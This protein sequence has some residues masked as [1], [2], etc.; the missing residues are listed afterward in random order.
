MKTKH[1]AYMMVLAVLMISA[2]FYFW[3]GS[4]FD[5]F[6]IKVYECRSHNEPLELFVELKDKNGTVIY[7]RGGLAQTETI[8]HTYNQFMS[9][10]YVLNFSDDNDDVRINRKISICGFSIPCG[11]IRQ[12][13][14]CVIE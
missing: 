4:V 3:I 8:M 1:I 2:I 13:F 11:E 10:V 9:V 14:V 5:Q 7:E 12:G 6:Y